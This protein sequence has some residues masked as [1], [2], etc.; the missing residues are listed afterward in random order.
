MFSQ[1]C[2]ED[3]CVLDSTNNSAIFL[4]HI[5]SDGFNFLTVK[6]IQ[7]KHF[8]SDIKLSLNNLIDDSAFKSQ[9]FGPCTREY[10]GLVFL[11]PQQPDGT[12]P[13][14]AHPHPP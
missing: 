14:C 8:L 3:P 5:F 1:L 4:R 6:L 7:S 2:P 10:L 11:Q 12:S 9:T 13:R